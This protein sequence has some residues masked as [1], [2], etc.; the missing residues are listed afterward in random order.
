M[1]KMLR[2]DLDTLTI[3]GNPIVGAANKLSACEDVSEQTLANGA[4]LVYS[5]NDKK[6]ILQADSNDGGEF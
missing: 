5:S 2:N 1:V 6:Y 3:Y 4:I